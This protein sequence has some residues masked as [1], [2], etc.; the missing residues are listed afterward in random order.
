MISSGIHGDMELSALLA[1]PCYE[2]YLKTND[3]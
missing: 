3:A 2:F 1:M